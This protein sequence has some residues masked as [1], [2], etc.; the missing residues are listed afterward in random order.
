MRRMHLRALLELLLSLGRC[1]AWFFESR[2]RL[3]HFRLRAI[4]LFSFVLL[5]AVYAHLGL[6]IIDY[7]IRLCTYTLVD[8]N[9]DNNN[10]NNTL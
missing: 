2:L 8:P 3:A 10:N 7:I 5:L 6:R 1:L 9:K 4:P